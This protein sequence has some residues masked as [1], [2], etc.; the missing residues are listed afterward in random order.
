M[1]KKEEEK[2]KKEETNFKK[3]SRQIYLDYRKRSFKQKLQFFI[4]RKIIKR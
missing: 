1:N 3:I 4:L 2:E